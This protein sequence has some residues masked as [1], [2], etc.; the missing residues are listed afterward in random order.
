MTKVSET[1]RWLLG[2]KAKAVDELTSQ[3]MDA[4]RSL[5]GHPGMTAFL[6]VLLTAQLAQYKMLGHLPL[7]T[8]EEAARASVTQGTIKGIE[9]VMQTLLELASADQANVPE[10]AQA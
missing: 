4:L 8:P 7:G 10:G 1:E 2:I 5:L 9:M 6:S 3:E